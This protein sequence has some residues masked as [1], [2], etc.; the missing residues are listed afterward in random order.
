MMMPT[1]YD[2]RMDYA[3]LGR[4]LRAARKA[5]GL[6][7]DEVADRMGDVSRQ[8]ISHWER[9]YAPVSLENLERFADVVG[10]RL[11]LRLPIA[12]A[13]AT[14]TVSREAA[15]LAEHAERLPQPARSLLAELAEVMP[16]LPPGASA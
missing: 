13:P 3:D 10:H 5:A 16:L 11:D 4:K 9:G 15:A 8:T 1:L 7:Q 14:V 6:T 2:P 12:D